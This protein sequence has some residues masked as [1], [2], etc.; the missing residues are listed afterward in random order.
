M[1]RLVF[2]TFHGERRHDAPAPAHCGGRGAVVHGD[3]PAKAGSHA[4][5][6]AATR[7]TSASRKP[8]SGSHGHA[9]HE[10]PWSMAIPLILLAIGSVVAGY[11]GVPHA[12]ARQQ[13]D[14]VVPGA[15]VRGPRGRGP[16]AR[17]PRRP[18][19]PAPL[20]AEA[21]AEETH[22]DTGHR[23]E[24]DDLLERGCPGRHRP[25]DLLLVDQPQRRGRARPD[26]LLRFIACCSG[27]TTS[28]RP[29]TPRSFSR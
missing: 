4:V 5:G 22:A 11:V 8:R 10:A 12:L 17:R 25:R 21:G 26:R 1:F 19:R 14:R 28:T 6:H 15:V 27:S 3:L 24:P 23:A 18:P 16:R 13:P 9:P 29:T 7:T 2:L 20:A